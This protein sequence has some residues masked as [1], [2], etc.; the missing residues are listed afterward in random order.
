MKSYYKGNGNNNNQLQSSDPVKVPSKPTTIIKFIQKDYYGDSHLEN[1]IDTDPKSSLPAPSSSILSHWWSWTFAI[2]MCPYFLFGCPFHS[3][4]HTEKP[5]TNVRAPTDTREW[6]KEI[7]SEKVIPSIISCLLLIPTCFINVYT[8]Y[9]FGLI[10]NSLFI[11]AEY[12]PHLGKSFN[13][14]FYFLLI[15]LPVDYVWL[16]GYKIRNMIQQ[17]NKLVL[18]YKGVGCLCFN[19][20]LR[21]SSVIILITGIYVI[22]YF[23]RMRY[24]SEWEG[25]ECS[26]MEKIEIV[27]ETL[28]SIGLSLTLAVYVTFC[29]AVKFHFMIIKAL[30]YQWIKDKVTPTTEHLNVVKIL[31]SQVSDCILQ[32]NGWCYVYMSAVIL[33]VIGE[34]LSGPRGVIG[35]LIIKPAF[36]A[37]S[38][39]KALEKWGE[40]QENSSDEMET[41]KPNSKLVREMNLEILGTVLMLGLLFWTIWQAVRTN[42]CARE[43][44]VWLNDFSTGGSG[45]DLKNILKGL[46]LREKKKDPR[47]M[48][49]EGDIGARNNGED[50][51]DDMI[52]WARTRMEDEMIEKVRDFMIL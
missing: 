23:T 18:K 2:S 43:I 44:H 38:L 45:L 27:M 26:T 15:I 14:F 25:S 37:M 41:S 52:I 46:G 42:D 39:L 28:A 49:I 19:F 34:I 7:F 29:F 21:V 16:H 22:R 4:L 48:V 40:K 17:W 10:V 24:E 35:K 13:R 6:L 8:A 32:I 5:A 20:R 31:Y 30:V 9:Q 11:K 3:L 36:S 33:R 51:S 12:D 47:I 1:D 50:E